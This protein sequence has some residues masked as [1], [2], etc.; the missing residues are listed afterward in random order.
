M[1]SNCQCTLA[2]GRGAS[3]EGIE[4]SHPFNSSRGADLGYSVV[5]YVRHTG[6]TVEA[7]SF[8]Y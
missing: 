3:K 6:N 2:S 1:N 4:I 7:E 5:A 8:C